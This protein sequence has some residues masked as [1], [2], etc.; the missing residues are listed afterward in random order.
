MSE[1]KRQKMIDELASVKNKRMSKTRAT[2]VCPF[3]PD[4]NPSATVNLDLD[5]QR[6]P[7]G[8]F[9]CFACRKSVPWN[10]LA[11]TLGLKTIGKGKKNADDYVDPKRFK[12]ELLD[13]EATEET[14]FER[15][16]NEDLTFFEFQ[17]EEWRGVKRELLEKT[18]CRL[19][20]LDRTGEFYV[21]M[22]VMVQGEMKG[23][24]KACLEKPEEGPSYI[25]ASGKWSGQYGFLFYDYAVELA[26]RKGLNTVVLVEGPRDALRLL[27][28][29]IPAMAVLGALNWNE[30]KRY[31]LEQ[32]GIENLILFF[33]G[34][35]AGIAA[36]K[37]IYKSVKTCFNIRKV[38]KL[39]RLRVPR[40]S[41][42]TGKQKRKKLADGNYRLLWDNELDPGN[43]PLKHL[44]TVRDALV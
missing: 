30:E 15:E 42:K 5:N 2:I 35:D 38:M 19:C 41:K 40:I 24:V 28:Y 37:G 12:D 29:G 39:W 23:Y 25:N 6:V 21:W 3:H 8:W 31:V 13:A 26:M 9:N 1:S 7:L 16:L 36:T 44:R 4:R 11:Q 17:Q 20:Y 33:D 14:G 27:R 43:C 18:G 34:D 22:P 32:S 10:T